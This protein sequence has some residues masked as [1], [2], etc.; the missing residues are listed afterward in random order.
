MLSPSP[1]FNLRH[2]QY[3]PNSAHG[4]HG[5]MLTTVDK[6]ASVKDDVQYKDKKGIIRIRSSFL[7]ARAELLTVNKE[8]LISTTSVHSAET[9]PL[10][11]TEVAPK[12]T[13]ETRSSIS[14][15]KDIFKQKPLKISEPEGAIG[16]PEARPSTSEHSLAESSPSII[17]TQPSVNL[18]LYRKEAVLRFGLAHVAGEHQCLEPHY[19]DAFCGGSCL[20][21]FPS[22]DLSSDHRITRLFHCDF[23]CQEGL[24]FCVV[25]KNLR[26][27][28]DQTLNVKLFMHNAADEELLVVLTGRV[29]TQSSRLDGSS[30]GIQHVYPLRTADEAVLRELREYLLLTEPGF[31]VPIENHFGWKVRSVSFHLIIALSLGRERALEDG[32]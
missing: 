26:E 19:G 10:S 29:L 24:I 30:R 4:P 6:L 11:N 18:R 17:M 16:L 13:K 15:L 28:P 2:Q 27:H 8:S 21:L 12:T 14:T 22:D 7:Q 5:Y 9:P 25:T 23:P 20:K 3:Q 32:F 1:W 31:Y